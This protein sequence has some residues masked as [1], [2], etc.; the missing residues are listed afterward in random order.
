MISFMVLG[1]PRSG[2]TWAA[3]WLTTDETLCLHDPLLEY[4]LKSLN[5]ILFTGKKLGISCTASLLYPA[6]VAEQKCPKVVLY[7]DV[8]EINH[9]LQALGLAE[10]MEIKHIERI[11]WVAILPRTMLVPYE[12]LFSPSAA[13]RIAEHLGVPFCPQRHNLLRQ[14]NVQ[15]Q[16]RNLNIGREAIDQLTA[17]II[18]ARAQEEPQ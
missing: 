18:E 17:R 13:Q 16:W 10:L 7:R 14:M 11:E 3:N 1:G 9:S 12:F 2:T 5:N 8:K 6:W 15:P 4:P